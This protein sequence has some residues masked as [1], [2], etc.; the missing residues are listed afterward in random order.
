MEL[1]LLIIIALAIVVSGC[2]IYFKFQE[3]FNLY[4]HVT[5]ETWAEVRIVAST[6]IEKLVELYDATKQGEDEFVKEVIGNIKARIDNSGILTEQEKQ[7]FNIEIL[8]ALFTPIIKQI[9]TT[10][11]SIEK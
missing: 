1:L 2:I 9:I 4:K 7:F 6:T 8:T 3:S 11:D 5:P 10:F